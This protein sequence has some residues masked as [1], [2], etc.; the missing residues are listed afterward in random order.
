[1]KALAICVALSGGASL[2][3]QSPLDTI[4]NPPPA[5]WFLWLGCPSPNVYFD[6]AVN[7]TIT[8]QG[9][10]VMLDDLPGIEGTV[11]LYVTNAGITSYLGN[12]LNV[13]N[14]TLAGS[15]VVTA[16][17]Y[18]ASSIAPTRVGFGAGVVLQP[19]SYGL[20]VHYSGVRAAFLSATAPVT[21][22]TTEATMTVGSV[23]ALSF[24][25]TPFANY[26]W[27][28]KLHYLPGAAASSAAANV[29]Y[30]SGCNTTNGSFFQRFACANT[31]NTALSGKRLGLTFTGAGY[32]ATP[33]TAAYVAPTASAV[34]L[35]ASDDGETMIALTNPLPYP[36]GVTPVL[37]VNSNGFVSVAS[38]LA[39]TPAIYWP[40]VDG[41][42]SAP[43]AAW[44]SWH[45]YNPTETGS[46][47]IKF[48]EVGAMVYLTWEGVESYPALSGTTP[49][50]NQSTF[51]FQFDTG[52]GNVTYVWQ[53][54]T[55]VGGSNFGDEHVIGYSP[56]GP[57]PTTGAIDLATLTGL[58]L[59]EPEVLPL[60][61]TAT[62][63]PLLGNTVDYVTGSEN[64]S[65]LGL[66]FFCAAPLPGISLAALGMPECAAHVDIGQGVGNIISNL[67]LPGLSMTVSVPVPN[68]A[69][70]IGAELFGQSIWLDPAA[71]P[72]GAVTSNGLRT[73]VGNF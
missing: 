45:D 65:N 22:T 34:A 42:L 27:L 57:S 15:A 28:G 31:A 16:A 21:F 19:G 6:L 70:L 38:N 53:T 29:E 60:S 56:G 11:E 50:V 23:Q 52:T 67:G 44:Y 51:Q 61:L 25:S 3:A 58:V 4:P 17:G 32:V 55:G 40:S 46:G 49:V 33:S 43:Q 5:N 10:D 71:N 12:E 13:A 41:V 1:M 30:G 36:G 2:F 26:D 72:F 7:T 62:P 20:A 69:T 59:A 48:E 35:P 73:R 47:R 9:M 37:Y 63:A 54:I 39:L 14:W 18:T 68:V 64:G 8:L 66:F 24:A